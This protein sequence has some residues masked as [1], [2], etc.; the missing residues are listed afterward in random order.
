MTFTRDLEHELRRHV[1]ALATQIGERNIWCRGSLTAAANYVEA[2]WRSQGY[3][4]APQACYAVHG[5]TCRN[6]EVAIPGGARS[7]E[8]LLVGAHYDTVCAS[9]GAN[10]NASGVAALLEIARMLKGAQPAQ[11]LRLL[12]FV[13]EESPFF[14]SD[15]MG[16][17][18]YARAARARHD[19]ITLMLSLEMLGCYDDAPGSQS[20]PPF[21]R[22][23]YP[24]RGNFIAF[25]SNL[26]GRQSLRRLAAA[27][28][29][30]S[31]FPCE[32]LAAPAIVPGLSWSDH[33]SFLQVGYKAVMVTDTAFY[34]Y[35][36]Y[37]SPD[38]TEEKLNY[39]SMAQVVDG[40]ARA[41]AVMAGGNPPHPRPPTA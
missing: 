17:A 36:H 41:L 31:Q 37:H 1:A 33:R 15:Q 28:R 18:I 6:L 40:L 23:F 39:R 3:S 21:L 34:R 13:N 35:R 38:D 24:D 7:S 11:T 4:V 5:E 29:S 14:R 27:F 2:E 22:P 8:I 10:D 26:G 30:Q 20:Y 16:S 9:P 19:N 12:A 25:V 32:T